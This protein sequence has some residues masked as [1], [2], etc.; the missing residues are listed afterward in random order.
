MREKVSQA[1]TS[2]LSGK[3]GY[4]EMGELCTRLLASK[5]PLHSEPIGETSVQPEG[6][7]LQVDE[8][9]PARPGGQLVE[10]VSEFIGLSAGDIHG[11]R[12][13]LRRHPRGVKPIGSGELDG[14]ALQVCIGDFPMLLNGKS[15]LHRRI[16][17]AR[18]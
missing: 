2:L 18:Q 3:T 6:H 7:L 15:V 16:R 12:V 5:K 1:Q 13:S 14:T 4:R 8:E 9:V 10:H 17:Q 11:G